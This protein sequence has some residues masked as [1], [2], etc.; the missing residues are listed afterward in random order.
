MVKKDKYTPMLLTDIERIINKSLDLLY[1]KDEELFSND[2]CE[3][4]IAYKFGLYFYQIMQEEK[5]SD[6]DIDME[7]NRHKADLKYTQKLT[8]GTYPDLIVHKRNTD[9]KNLL[10][11]EF[12][13]WKDNYTIKRLIKNDI[14]KIEEFVDCRGK[15][16]Y[17]Y[18]ASIIFAKER[19]DVIITW[20]W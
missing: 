10:V 13:K 1:S 11:I 20:V 18:G 3:R 6:Y 12:K 14:T 4:S 17:K 7:Y 9:K 19:K 16:S 15:Y 2:L 8:N 5:H